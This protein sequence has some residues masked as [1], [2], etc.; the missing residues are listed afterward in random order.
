M[1]LRCLILDD[2]PLAHKVIL[3]YAKEVPYL[4]IVAQAY[5]PTVAL[6]IL[7]EQQIDL[8]FLDIQMPKLNGLEM[9]RLVDVKPEV[10]ITSAY[11]E[12]ALE[13]Y[14]LKVCDYLLKPFRL[15]RFLRA[16]EQALENYR[17]KHVG[18]D[19]KDTVLF[20][21]SE[22]RLVQVDK[23]DICYL[24]SYGNYVKIW[25]DSGFIL[26]ANT[27][28]SFEQELEGEQFFR[29]HKS[30]LINKAKIGFVE[31]NKVVMKNEVRLPVSKNYKAD[32]LEFLK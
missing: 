3:K 14:E 18:Q 8:L 9:L 4:D 2:E 22:K 13:S 28:S 7:K 19:V 31:G 11:E 21:K 27:L 20:V 26:T 5:L 25:R 30:Y 12:Y 10:I 24:E 29:I 6:E 1:K 16:T 15:G 32:F 23:V 17:M